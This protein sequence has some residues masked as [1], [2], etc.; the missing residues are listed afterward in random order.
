MEISEI[1][2][3]FES[4]DISS[5]KEFMENLHII[6]SNCDNN[7]KLFIVNSLLKYLT[8]KDLVDSLFIKCD[9]DIIY[10]GI[11]SKYANKTFKGVG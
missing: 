8:S 4:L 7:E 2:E 11:M 9:K 6:Y 5:S 10:Y 1:I 3:I